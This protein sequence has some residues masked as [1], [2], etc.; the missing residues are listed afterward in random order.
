PDTMIGRNIDDVIHQVNCKVL[1]VQQEMHEQA[2]RIM[3]PVQDP[4]QIRFSLEAIGYVTGA[5]VVEKV[6]THV[7]P[8]DSPQDI[9]DAFMGQVQR[10]VQQFERRFP[11]TQGSIKMQRIL[12]NDPIGAIVKA[13][14]D[15]DYMVIGAT[16]DGW[17]KRRFFDSTPKLLAEQVDIPVA[18]TRPRTNPFSFGVRQILSYI[19]GGYLD[20]D[21]RSQRELVDLGLLLPV[22]EAKPFD[23]TTGVNK[24][25]ISIMGIL[26]MGSAIAM[27]VGDGDTLT[28]VGA[29]VFILVLWAFTWLTI[30]PGP[31]DMMAPP[32][33]S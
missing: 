12:S 9:Q 8:K 1:V 19:W 3:I 24:T 17:L 28:W 25:A 32:K 20:I 4:Q 26:A 27:Y 5:P 30:R 21:P 2:Q 14:K 6:I 18:V 22:E 23:P 16:R 29:I 11:K 10:E 7:F 15:Y 33:D 31:Q 13:S